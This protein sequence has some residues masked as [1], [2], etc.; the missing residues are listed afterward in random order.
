MQNMVIA[1]H[2][3]IN[4]IYM[5]RFHIVKSANAYVMQIMCIQYTCLLFITFLNSYLGAN[6]NGLIELGFV[7]NLRMSLF[8]MHLFSWILVD[9]VWFYVQG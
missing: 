9:E 8:E 7:E 4:Y 3:C 5:Y 2:V 6:T 1:T